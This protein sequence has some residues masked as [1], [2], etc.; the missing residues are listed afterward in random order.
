[1]LFSVYWLE[2][3]WSYFFSASTELKFASN[4][5]S[6]SAERYLAENSGS[7]LFNPPLMG[8]SWERMIGIARR[9][10][11]SKFLQLGPSKLT[12][13]VLTTLMAELAA[14]INAQPLIPVSTNLSDAIILDPATLLTQKLSLQLLPTTLESKKSSKNNGANTW[15]KYFGANG[16]SISSHHCSQ[17]GSGRPLGLIWSLW[18]LCPSKISIS[19]GM[20]GPWIFPSKDNN[21]CKVEI[22][23]SQ[24]DGTNLFWELV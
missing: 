22:K 1:M 8:G 20:N 13:K 23:L 12:H 6:N 4:I 24:K 14:I 3:L 15:L 9:I 17:G 7:W 11:D 5:D 10:L 16:G 18:A 21:V 2:V 19:R